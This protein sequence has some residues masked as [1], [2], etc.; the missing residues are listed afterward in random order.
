MARSVPNIE[1]AVSALIQPIERST[2]SGMDQGST[3]L[4]DDGDVIVVAVAE[5]VERHGPSL[6]SIP[7]P[8]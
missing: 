6:K 7:G 2:H 3:G 4:D 5:P 8:D 1:N